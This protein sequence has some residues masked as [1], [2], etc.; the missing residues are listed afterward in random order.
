MTCYMSPRTFGQPSCNPSFSWSLPQKGIKFH[1]LMQINKI[2]IFLE[3]LLQTSPTNMNQ[4][5]AF[6][7]L[8]S[9]NTPD[10][11][12]EHTLRF[13]MVKT[14]IGNGYHPATGVFIVPV[15]GVYVFTWTIRVDAHNYHTT[16]LMKNTEGVD[17]VHLN[18]NGGIGEVT[19]IAVFMA[20]EGDDVFIETYTQFNGGYIS[21]DAAGRSSFSGWKLA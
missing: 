16:Q 6:H 3:R 12:V 10:I 4:I 21:S 13:D 8:M 20:N 11:T 5:V 19:G 9:S 1:K 15:T 14:N 2:F 18:P 7:A 17:V